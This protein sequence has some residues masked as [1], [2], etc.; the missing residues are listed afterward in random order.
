[1]IVL[2]D[3]P[4]PECISFGARSEPQWSTE[5]AA[6]VAGFDSSTQNWSQTRHH[7]DVS[8][9][10]RTADDYMA[11]RAHFHKVRGRAKGFLFKDPIDYSATAAHD[12][13]T[14]TQG[15]TDEAETSSD[16]FQ[17]FKRY[18]TGADFYD[19]KITRPVTGTLTIYRTRSAVTT[20]VT[21]SAT[22]DYSGGTF[23]VS[24]DAP[25]DVYTWA[26]EFRVPCRY[27]TDRLPGVIINKEPSAQGQLLVQCES[28]PVVE[29]RE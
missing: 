25:G 13:E 11:V 8:L 4:F 2:N 14:D 10:V 23:T 12:A 29:V 17:L 16:G 19:R 22:V 3:A 24:G 20:D 15:V 7:Y 9:A 27:D 26:G 18:G 5:I 21:G 1:M 28:I 6:S